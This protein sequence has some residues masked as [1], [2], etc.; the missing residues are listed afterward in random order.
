MDKNSWY[1]LQ[2]HGYRGA[3]LVLS[4]A[5]ALQ[6]S[7]AMVS[8]R[9]KAWLPFWQP[10]KTLLVLSFTVLVA[11]YTLYYIFKF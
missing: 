6:M 7:V 4:V 1:T 5:I 11:E 3:T 8:E 10:L 2:K 9:F